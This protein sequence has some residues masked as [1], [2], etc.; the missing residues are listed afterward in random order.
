MAPV[1]FKI[2]IQCLSSPR[3]Y[4][5][6][7]TAASQGF[8]YEPKLL[9]RWGDVVIKS[10]WVL[11]NLKVISIPVIGFALYRKCYVALTGIGLLLAA[12]YGLRAVGRSTNEVYISFLRTLIEAQKDMKTHKRTLL[13]YDFDFSSWPVE[14][15]W[16]ET[17]G[18]ESKQRIFLNTTSSQ[19]SNSL[20]DNILSLPIKTIGYMVAH[21]VGYKLMFPGSIRTLQFFID[22]A[23]VQGRTKLI[24]ENRA[25][26][27]K[28]LTR[29]GNEL[30]SVFVDR[31]KRHDNGD[32]LVICCEGNAGF[33]EIGIMATPLGCGYSVL[34]WNYPGFGWSSGSP[35][36]DHVANG[37]DTVMQFAI[38]KLNFQP[39]NII[40]F[41]WSI[42]GY[43]LSWASM[44]YP[45]VKG[46]IV[47]ASFDDVV[48]LAQARFPS[49]WG[50]LV[51]RIVRDYM[52]LNN[53][54]QLSR[55]PGP[56]LFFRRTQDEIIA[57]DPDILATNRGNNLVIKVLQH[58]Y[59]RLV[60][61]KALDVLHDWLSTGNPAEQ[62]SLLRKF[63]VNE[64]LC[65][66][67]L[68]SY[69]S[70][71]S[72]KYPMMIGEEAD[73]KELTKIQLTLFLAR[74]YLQDYNSTHCTPLPSRLFVLPWDISPDADFVKL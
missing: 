53:A 46:A 4:R 33:Y 12:S 39:E 26:R 18:D 56:T 72:S 74:R 23:I 21:G 35:Y 9:E 43:A 69:V 65:T 11:L 63:N 50:P 29:D 45:E 32:I 14:F 71:Y 60:E 22:N 31:R 68:A 24:E 6:H 62:L 49:S 20:L 25:D 54:A 70:E 44:N 48:P 66:S 30:D 42:G 27:F 47:D 67:I 37:M 41:A 16:N 61:D 38:N 8:N 10:F 36:P 55:Y 7:S 51:K 59:P 2:L 52:N 57:I 28:M 17:E 73:F 58:R 3:L 5:I 40:L 19:N 64:D 15:R 34:G 1:Y 13:K